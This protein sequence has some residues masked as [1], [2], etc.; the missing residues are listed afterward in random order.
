[1]AA[2]TEERRAT[3]ET[4][5]R[6]VKVKLTVSRVC[7]RLTASGEPAGVYSQAPGDIVEMPADEAARNIEAGN[8]RPVE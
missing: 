5:A 6:M 7:Q 2:A 8:A 1:M 3:K 4:P